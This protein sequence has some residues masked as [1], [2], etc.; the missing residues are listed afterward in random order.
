MFRVSGSD[1]KLV[2]MMRTLWIPFFA[3][4][5]S[6]GIRLGHAQKAGIQE[7]ATARLESEFQKHVQPVLKSFCYRCHGAEKKK[8]GV[9]V[10][11]LD[12][13]LEDKQL[14]IHLNK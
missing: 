12:G 4:F 3:V 7:I 14:T 1:P 5:L 9:R 6:A 13:S 8:S 10:D 2:L 11:I